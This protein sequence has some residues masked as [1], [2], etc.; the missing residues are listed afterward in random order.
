V[1]IVGCISFV[2]VVCEYCCLQLRKPYFIP[3]RGGN[4]DSLPISSSC[5]SAAVE[6]KPV[7][8]LPQ[9]GVRGAPVAYAEHAHYW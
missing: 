9:D 2:T 5:V 3:E 8:Q 1:G 4:L 7:L 6:I